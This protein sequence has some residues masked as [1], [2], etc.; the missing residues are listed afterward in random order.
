[1][2]TRCGGLSSPEGSVCCLFPR[3]SN[4]LLEQGLSYC[5]GCQSTAER[6]P[7]LGRI[8][9]GSGD[10]RAIWGRRLN[11]LQQCSRQPLSTL[12]A[13]ENRTPVRQ[14]VTEPATTIPGSPSHSCRIGGST[15]PKA[16]CRVFPRCQRSFT[17]SVVFPYGPPTLLLPGCV[18]LAPCAIAGHGFALLPTEKD[19]A[20]RANCSFLAVHLVPPFN[21]SE[22]TRVANSTSRSQRRNQSAPCADIECTPGRATTVI[23][24]AGPCG[25]SAVTRPA[26]T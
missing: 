16:Y 14:V 5:R 22:T 6:N 9:V 17:P 25:P 21:E 23:E 26:S 2:F 15:G 1:M 7:C 20:A 19:Q 3:L 8:E 18:D 24:F 12:G 10:S 13:G 4:N 11:Q